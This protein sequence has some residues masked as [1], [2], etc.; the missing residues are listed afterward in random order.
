M[1]TH[2]KE[3]H[4]QLI[5]SIKKAQGTLNKVIEMVEEWK[6]CV[7]IA[8]QIS[9]SIGLLKGANTLLLKSHLQCCGKE[10][11]TSK[12]EQERKEFIEELV[13][14]RQATNK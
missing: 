12:N 13:A 6:Y 1:H 9:A 4:K 7:D 5:L 2:S 3:Y 8:Q 14:A 11:L 10:K